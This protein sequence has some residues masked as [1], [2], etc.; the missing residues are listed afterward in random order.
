MQEPSFPAEE[1]ERLAAL[2]SLRVLDTAPEERFDRITRLAQRLF[3]VPIVLVSLVDQ[4]RQWFKSAQGL[5]ARETPRDISFCGHAIHADEVYVVE[6]TLR[7]PRFADN[8]LVTGDP[9]IRFYA[10]APLST[11]G[12]YRIGTLCL[13]DRRPR[14]FSAADRHAL[15]DLAVWVEDELGRRN[16]ELHSKISYEQEALLRAILSTVVDGIITIDERGTVERFN[17]AAV[18]IFGYPPEEVIG[19][20]INCLMPEPYRGE[21]DGYLAQFLQTRAPRVIGIG[22]EVTGCRKDGTTFPMELAVSEAVVAGRRFFTGIVRDISA[23]KADEKRLWDTTTLQRAILNGTT[24][25]IISTALDGTILTFNHAAE[26]MLGY[27]ADEVVGR[28]TPALLHDP[29]E[30]AERAAELSEELGESIKPGFDVFVAKARRDQVDEREWTYLHKQGHRI[31][32][33]LS[34]TPLRDSAKQLSGFLGIAYDI[35]ER[36]KIERLKSEFVSTVSHELRTPLTSIRGSL[37]L[38]AGG[39]AGQLPAQAAKL[40]D[41]AYNNSERLV[42]LIN[43]IL[44]IEK[45]ESGKM[46]F[47]LLAQP[48]RPVILQAI[49]ANRAFAEQLQVGIELRSGDTDGWVCIDADRMMQ[50]VTN[51]LSNAAKFSPTHDAVGV[52]L[53]ADG[54]RL[55]LA[56]SDRGPGISADFQQRIFQ[57]FSQADSSDTRRLAGTGL[58][59]AITRSLVQSM[60]GE[61]GFDTSSAG[62]TFWVELPREASG[63]PAIAPGADQSVLPGVLICE[64]DPDVADLLKH[65]LE[66]DGYRVDVADDARQARQLL[67]QRTYA[68]LTLDIAF[69]DVDGV[70]L[71]GNLRNEPQARDLPIIVVSA[72]ALDENASRMARI[73]VVDWLQKPV[74]QERL[75]AALRRCMPGDSRRPRILHVDDDADVL[76]VVAAIA[77]GLADFDCATDLSLARELLAS[78]TYDLVIL[79]LSLPDGCGSELLP[80]ISALEPEPPVLVFSASDVPRQEAERFAACLVKS[81]T[82]NGDLLRTIRT[83]IQ[84]ASRQ[85]DSLPLD[86]PPR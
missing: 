4:C 3:D 48:L 11:A 33:L 24:Y 38:I 15:R 42:R 78:R 72:D 40:I 26:V 61:I 20:N 60:G 63:R 28:Q 34:V 58:G 1:A 32:V 25:S 7:D 36:K 54:D 8:P 84:V 52:S 43:D 47:D 16:A 21:H 35:S 19:R 17:P 85:R 31:P 2:Q 67:A 75:L 39:V 71:I 44:D 10:G 45:I 64:D 65:L 79:D 68:A 13:I 27:Q 50:V 77:G 41:I 22:R 62:T 69:P 53:V 80:A 70:T 66:N 29:A 18:R 86:I 6:D 30:V 76:R 83:Q 55:R 5:A 37:G 9:D 46:Q 56:V 23:R 12:G 74:D 49:E 81:V 73:P 51:L 59:L 57:K 14:S 82:T